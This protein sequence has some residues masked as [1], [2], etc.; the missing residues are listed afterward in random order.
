MRWGNGAKLQ[1]LSCAKDDLS[2]QLVCMRHS[3]HMAPGVKSNW[4][5]G[6]VKQEVFL[7]VCRAC[8]CAGSFLPVILLAQR[9]TI[10]VGFF[11]ACQEDFPVFVQFSSTQSGALKIQVP[12]V[13]VIELPTGVF[14]DDFFPI[15]ILGVGMAG[16]DFIDGQLGVSGVDS[17]SCL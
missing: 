8:N 9:R 2:L 13:S 17:Q 15:V 7:G 1:H 16:K 12:C 3:K 5:H 11:S 10:Y 4:E 6:E 14:H